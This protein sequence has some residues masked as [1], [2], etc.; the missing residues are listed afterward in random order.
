MLDHLIF[1][2]LKWF[3]VA[4]NAD[5]VKAN[6]KDYVAL[7]TSFTLPKDTYVSDG[8]HQSGMNI[9][10]DCEVTCVGSSNDFYY[11]CGKIF[12][13]WNNLDSAEFDIDNPKDVENSVTFER[14]WFVRKSKV[15]N[16]KW[17]GKALLNHLYQ[18]FRNLYRMVVIA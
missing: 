17:G 12:T 18:W 2:K 6:N 10:R 13:D 3:N 14:P 15:T 4:D 7:P 11:F 8:N 5:S 1:N 9:S 16:V